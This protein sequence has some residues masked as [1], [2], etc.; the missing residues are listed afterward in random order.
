[1]PGYII[2]ESNDIDAFDHRHQDVV[3]VLSYDYYGKRK[4]TGSADHRLRVYDRQGD[5]SWRLIDT[6]RGHDAEIIDAKWSTPFMGQ[7]V[8]SIGED[9]RF[10]VWQ[11]DVYEPANS[12]HRFKC[13]FTLQSSSRIPFV[14]FDFK[15]VNHSDVFVALLSRDAML[16][17]Y[18]ANEPESVASWAIVDQ[19]QV[20]SPPS[21]GEETSFKV[22]FDPNDMPCIG[23]SRA[24][25]RDDALSLVTA[26]MSTAKVWRSNA[27]RHFYPAADLTAHH[28]PHH[29]AL[30]RD[31]AWAPMNSRGWDVIATTCTDGFIRI[32]EV[33]APE[34][35]AAS[36]SFSSEPGDS[37]TSTVVVDRNMPGLSR[38]RTFNA[39]TTS[40]GFLGPIGTQSL[41]GPSQS[42]SMTSVVRPRTQRQ[43]QHQHQQHRQQSH[44]RQRPSGIGAELAETASRGYATW[45]TIA[46]SGG[47]AA[48]SSRRHHRSF[49]DD[50]D[51]DDDD[52]DDDDEA[53]EADDDN[54]D[55]DNDNGRVAHS[56]K[57][58][59]AIRE[60]GY[61]A[62]EGLEL[63]T[64][65]EDGSIRLWKAAGAPCFPQPSSTS[66][67]SS[68]WMEYSVVHTDAPSS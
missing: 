31:V 47:G 56:V 33:H 50:A 49:Q 40:S 41:A 68:S 51:D 19:F 14:S 12:G 13:V 39:G 38:S 59:A 7:I 44:H 22:E 42:H 15:T 20:C 24:G 1:M 63:I 30:V 45:A 61:G 54:N 21:R 53:D 28:R 48:S 66:S 10:K 3:T 4:I 27:H 11:E 26:G 9:Q 2:P 17:V 65:H 60:V 55:D 58:V 18:E 46:P 6:W 67:S 37:L 5:G 8:G 25:L 29:R 32:F 62:F 16:T 43:H 34:S 57:E 64:S 36:N 35:S 52:D 23:A